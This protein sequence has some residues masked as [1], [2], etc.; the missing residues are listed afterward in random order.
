MHEALKP[1]QPLR[2]LRDPVLLAAFSGWVDRGGSAVATLEYLAE[3]WEAT[4][5]AELD[6][7]PFYDFTVNRPR[8]RLEAGQRAIDWPSNRFF[9]AQ[10]P[11]A[12]SDFVLLA[13]VEPSLRWRTYNEAVADFMREVG[14]TTSITLGTRPAA[15]PHTRPLPVTLSASHPEFERQFGLE[16]PPSRYQGP[17]GIAGVMNL[18]H[19]SLEWR[20]ASLTALSPHYLT[21]GPNPNVA[22]AL[23]KMLDHGFQLSTPLDRLQERVESFDAQV[24]Q[25][26]NESSEAETY[27]RQLEESYDTDQPAIPALEQGDEPG[28]AELPPTE[29][30]L[31]DLE[32]FLRERRNPS[33]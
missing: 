2:P 17:I 6:P 28:G 24:R 21:M 22:I 26:M 23:M 4:P 29:D 12:E 3:A 18:H 30:L 20:N 1:L 10:P 15:V 27:V 14:A 31:D 5:V 33:S 8:V 19:R 32:R 16:T 25:A 11:G 9:L 7:E 13:G